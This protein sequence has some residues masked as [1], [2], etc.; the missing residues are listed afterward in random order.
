MEMMKLANEPIIVNEDEKTDKTQEKVNRKPV[1]R[2]ILNYK[3]INDILNDM[4]NAREP[5]PEEREITGKVKILKALKKGILSMLK[6]GYSVKATANFINAKV[7]PYVVSEAEIRKFLSEVTSKKKVSKVKK[8]SPVK[9]TNE[10]EDVSPVSAD[11]SP[12]VPAN[13]SEKAEAKDNIKVAMPKVISEEERI[14]LTTTVDEK[15][16][17]KAL[18]AKYDGARKLWHIWKGLAPE[19]IERFR[20]WLP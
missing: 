3:L 14:Y 8:I 6:K 1:V 13:V 16:E 17:A 2:K 15:D 4:D 9:K 10:E 7:S 11:S 5:S 20:K 19:E 12:S 18:G